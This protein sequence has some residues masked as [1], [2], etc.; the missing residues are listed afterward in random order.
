MIT[1]RVEYFDDTSNSY[2]VVYES[3]TKLIIEIESNEGRKCIVGD[4]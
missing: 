3:E 4:V 1:K 2:S